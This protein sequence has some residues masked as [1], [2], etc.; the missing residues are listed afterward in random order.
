[1]AKQSSK[2]NRSYT[3]LNTAITEFNYVNGNFYLAYFNDTNHLESWSHA[4][5]PE[6]MQ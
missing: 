6:M 2:H 5:D 4:D 3:H 1:M